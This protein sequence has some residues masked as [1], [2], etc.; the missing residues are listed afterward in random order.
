MQKYAAILD[1]NSAS[2]LPSNVSIHK[3]KGIIAYH[4]QISN[5]YL[6]TDKWQ[7]RLLPNLEV[8]KKSTFVIDLPVI[9]L[10]YMAV[11]M[12]RYPQKYDVD[13]NTSFS[14]GL[15]HNDL[16]CCRQIIMV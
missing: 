13:G 8:D 9:N 14:V 5:W 15:D 4:N 6:Y 10:P 3:G 16:W 12:Y 1:D 2:R 7:V 11:R